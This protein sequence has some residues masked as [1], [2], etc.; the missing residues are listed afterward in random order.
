MAASG[1]S[2]YFELD[3]EAGNE[4][5]A[6]ASNAEVVAEDEAELLWAALERLPSQKRSNFALLRRTSS[7]SASSGEDWTRTIDVRK[8]DRDSR[9][10]V[11]RNALATS[12]QDN[13]NL[14]SAIKERLDRY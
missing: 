8:L 6:R 1:G 14:L 4:N 13:F 9:E 7:R 10:L 5:F 12:E 11:V 3:L 2:E